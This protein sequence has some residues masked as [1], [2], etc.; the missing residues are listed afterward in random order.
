MATENNITNITKRIREKIVSLG[1]KVKK[2]IEFGRDFSCYIGEI[3]CLH[4][5]I[6]AINDPVVTDA[7]KD[8]VID[9]VLNKYNI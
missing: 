1:F 3:N 6:I 7:N 8:I 5:V 4:N 9:F 2:A